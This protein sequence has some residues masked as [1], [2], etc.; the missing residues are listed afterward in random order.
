MVFGKIFEI[1]STGLRKLVFSGVAMLALSITASI[2]VSI[3]ILFAVLVIMWILK[4]KDLSPIDRIVFVMVQF[5][6]GSGYVMLG[7]ITMIILGLY[8]LLTQKK[9]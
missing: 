1:E 3:S 4:F 9:S 8:F 5:L 2:S 7:V 6:F